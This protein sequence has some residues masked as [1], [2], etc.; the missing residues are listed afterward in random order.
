MKVAWNILPTIGPRSGVGWYIAATLAALK[1][2]APADEHHLEFPGGAGKALRRCWFLVRP[3]MTRPPQS[4]PMEGLP[5]PRSPDREN[6]KTRALDWARAAQDAYRS[7]MLDR[8]H[9]NGQL[10]LYHEPNFLPVSTQAP[11]VTTFHDLSS[12]SHPEWHPIDRVRTFEKRAQ[13]GLDRSLHFFTLS[14]AMK[15]E[16]VRILG[17]A[18]GRITITP[19]GVRPHLRPVLGQAQAEVLARLGIPPGSFLHVGT[20]EPRKN[21]LLLARAWCALPGLVRDKHPLV[22]VGG[23]GWR[24]DDLRSF[25]A[26]TGFG[27]GIKHI[28][29]LADDDLPAVYSSALALVFPTKYEGF[30]MPPIEMMACGGAVIASTAAAVREVLDNRAHLV[31]IED[32]AGWR[33]AMLR[34]A[35]EPEWLAGLRSGSVRLA[36]RYTWQ[37]TAQAT[38][39]G[40]ARALA[41]PEISTSQAA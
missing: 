4:R 33:D 7:R 12:L 28:G 13:G 21:L 9:A 37:A 24:C 36:A 17:V 25:L 11:T 3:Y 35:N 16:M 14:Q 26:A 18:P 27:K 39:L 38:R 6:W 31:E 10:D 23:W 15:D 32:E 30:G 1:A 2:S 20:L 40:Y 22:L 29:Y 41:L 5:T 8:W 19:M 34:A